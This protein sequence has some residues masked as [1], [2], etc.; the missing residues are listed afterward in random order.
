[1]YK[2]EIYVYI[3]VFVCQA[4]V[5]LQD[6]ELEVLRAVQLERDRTSRQRFTSIQDQERQ[7]HLEKQREE[8][9]QLQKVHMQQLQEQEAW[10]RERQR[11]LLEMHEREQELSC[12]MEECTIKEAWLSNE[13][14]DL[15]QSREE[16]QK[17]LERLRDSTRTVE[18]EKE[19]LKQEMKRLRKQ[20]TLVNVGGASH[21]DKAQNV[22]YSSLSLKLHTRTPTH[23]G[24]SS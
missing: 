11:H 9:L 7:R 4:L 20:R 10:A 17:D 3:I 12:R 15:S 8:L 5:S 16:Y 2:F 19:K 21:L 23:R 18:K 24:H 1:M 6:S 14:D 22:K 13:R